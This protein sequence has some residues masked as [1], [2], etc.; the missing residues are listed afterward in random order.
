[1]FILITYRPLCCQGFTHQILRDATTCCMAQDT[2]IRVNGAHGFIFVAQVYLLYLLGHALQCL[3][4]HVVAVGF[5]ER[6]EKFYAAVYL[7]DVEFTHVQ[8]QAQFISQELTLLRH[9]L[10]EPVAVRVYLYRVIHIAAIVTAKDVALD[11]LVEDVEIDILEELRG[12]V[13]DG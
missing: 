11:E 4:A 9:L 12:Q 8:L 3:V 2:E 7:L 1:M 10:D 13:D 6:T 5:Y